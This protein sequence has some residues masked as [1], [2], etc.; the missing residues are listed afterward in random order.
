MELHISRKRRSGGHTLNHWHRQAE[1]KRDKERK[2][3]FVVWKVRCF[4]S[5][6]K[7]KTNKKK[8][9]K[10][11]D[12]YINNIKWC[13]FGCTVTIWERRMGGLRGGEKGTGRMHIEANRE[14]MKEDKPD[15]SIKHSIKSILNRFME[16]S[17]THSVGKSHSKFSSLWHI[18][19]VVEHIS[20]TFHEFFPKF[21]I[22]EFFLKVLCDRYQCPKSSW[23]VIFGYICSGVMY[24]KK[25]NKKS[26]NR[27]NRRIKNDIRTCG[28]WPIASYG[29]QS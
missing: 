9:N 8:P 15:K 11:I 5:S 18:L 7:E 1:K 22:R 23:V 27:P 26:D 21:Q 14:R 4:P 29:D 20:K 17:C 16:R 28:I 3:V 2:I 13:K 6:E 25:Q 24:S 12:S 10:L 19:N